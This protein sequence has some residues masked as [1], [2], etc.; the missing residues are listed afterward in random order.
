MNS[1]PIST[2][3]QSIIDVAT[4]H[5][6]SNGCNAADTL[7]FLVNL[8][9]EK[10]DLARAAIQYALDNTFSREESLDDFPAPVE[11]STK[12]NPTEK[13]AESI[14]TQPDAKGEFPTPCA[15]A[16]WMANFG[17]PQIPLNGK[18]P[19]ISDWP[20]QASCDPNQIKA[21]A[22]Q[23]PGC[24]FGSVARNHDFFMFEADSDKVKS[25]FEKE[26]K[27]FTSKLVV[28]S[29]EGRGHR[30]YRWSAGVANISQSEGGT[31]Y[32]DF[33]LRVDNQQTVSPGGIHPI[34]G[35]Q[36]RVI[37]MGT[38]EVPTQDEINFW[39][40]ERLQIKKKTVENEQ[41]QI[42][43]GSRNATLARIAGKM[44]REFGWDAEKIFD[45]L[46][47][48]NGNRC[49]P[50]LDL[51]EVKTIAN[52]IARYADGITQQIKETPLVGGR[53]AVGPR[54]EVP[55][56]PV[57]ERGVMV[58]REETVPD[59]DPS[60]ITGVYKEI[61]DL[62]CDGTTIPRQFVF[63]A[64]KVYI[65]AR[66]AGHTSFEG[67]DCDSR[68]YATVVG[69]TGTGKGLS[70]RRFMNNVVLMRGQDNDSTH[71]GTVDPLVKIINSADSG[72]GLKDVFFEHPTTYPVIIYVDEV[73]TLGQKAGEKKQPE[74]VSTIGELADTT[75]V[76]RVLAK[77]K[78]QKASRTTTARLAM[79]CCGQD[80][81]VYIS[82]FPG[83]GKLGFFDRCYPEFS[84]LVDA[85]KLPN[86]DTKAAMM[87]RGK[88][89][90]LGFSGQ[91]TIGPGV[92]SRLDEFWESQPVEIRKK[93]RFKKHVMLDMYMAA[94]GR[95]LRAA[96]LEDLDVAIR[97]FTRQMVIR[98]LVF[99]FEAPDRVGYYVGLLKKITDSMRN[100]LND[101]QSLAFVA[102]SHRD[103]QTITNAYRN[104]EL[105]V[106]GRAWSKFKEAHLMPIKVPAANGHMYEKFIPVPYE[107]EMWLPVQK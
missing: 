76:S 52:S 69:E 22:E 103:I 83:R 86:I 89:D 18:A 31:L 62:V 2:E 6:E 101:G 30:Y 92:E 82:S 35:R 70:W 40:S 41:L 1:A 85:G 75:Q 46:S 14:I 74:I 15:G 55:A 51:S 91:M 53:P 63:L 28:E 59:F 56:A 13:S 10:E 33:S 81:D 4:V 5:L 50:P 25:R 29:R 78:D 20:N 64:A 45:E 32:K 97:I 72:A 94:F 73:S 65:G 79:Y 87:I 27:K 80:G 39:N 7:K 8:R 11:E 17:I 93:V 42:L 38:P 106:F 68:Y 58:Q 49:E 43:S 88:I 95:G 47:E 3:Q 36:Y 37:R 66:M 99:T 102:M 104:N 26:G 44:R 77:R 67:L 54:I 24:N 71:I 34:T 105:E 16:L 107:H 23:F 19:R 90:M 9:R 96:E 61:V 60:V 12:I 57:I 98:R 48:I 100:R 21:W 84:P